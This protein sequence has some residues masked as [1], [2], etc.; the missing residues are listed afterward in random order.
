MKT[1]AAGQLKSIF[2]E[3]KDTDPPTPFFSK[4]SPES[5][6]DQSPACLLART[7]AEAPF[8]FGS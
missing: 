7:D 6:H 2:K 5:V 8:K 1:E 3:T 4:R